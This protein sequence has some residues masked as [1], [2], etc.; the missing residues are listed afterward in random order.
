MKEL[1][2]MWISIQDVLKKGGSFG[3][4]Y[5]GSSK[6]PEDAKDLI[7]WEIKDAH[8]ISWIL[9]SMEAHMVNN[10]C[11]FTTAN[12]TWEYLKHIYYLDNNAWRFQLELEITNYTKDNLTIE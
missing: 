10:L 3:V 9:G 4:I 1:F 8:I 12:E 11:S 7:A 5:D 2:N 6:A